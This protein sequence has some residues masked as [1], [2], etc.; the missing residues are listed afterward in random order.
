MASQAFTCSVAR[1]S[2]PG[3]PTR[4]VMVVLQEPGSFSHGH[5]VHTVVLES[6]NW[7]GRPNTVVEVLI[8]QFFGERPSFAQK[9]WPVAEG[10]ELN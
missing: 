7:L 5:A 10:T 9:S 2:A 4:L 6:H 1:N 3:L 8:P